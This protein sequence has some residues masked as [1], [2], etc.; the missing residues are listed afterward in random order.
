MNNSVWDV[1][2]MTMLLYAMYRVLLQSKPDAPNELMIQIPVT[3]SN[4][5]PT[6]LNVYVFSRDVCNIGAMPTP[7]WE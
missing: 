4:L 7:E 1:N 2:N 3:C 6:I 5:L